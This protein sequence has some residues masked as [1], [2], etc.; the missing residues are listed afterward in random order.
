MNTKTLLLTTLLSSTLLFSN[1]AKEATVSKNDDVKRF[2]EAWIKTK[3]PNAT[4]TPLGVYILGSTEGTGET[5]EANDFI[6]V[7]YTVKSLNN[8]IISTN[9]AEVAKQIGKYVPTY[10]YGTTIWKMDLSSISVG[11]LDAVKGMKIGGSKTIL[12]PGWLNVH[13]EHK[14]ESEYLEKESGN[15]VIC[16]LTLQKKVKD[17]NKWEE[18]ILKEFSKKMPNAKKEK[19]GLYI[20]KLRENKN[21]K[22]ELK[23]DTTV[24]I[25]YTGRLL[26]G[27]VFDTTIED[28]AK[29]YNIYSENKKY[30]PVSIQLSKDYKKIKIN[31]KDLIEGFKYGISL[32]NDKEKVIFIFP[33]LLG[34][35]NKNRNKEAIPDHSP[36]RF[37]V[38]IIGKK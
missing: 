25:N 27:E 7:G 9:N 6:F 18:K 21:K 10:P 1:C 15:T 2:I 30:G 38:E 19:E 31:N 32:M 20:Q 4:K 3:H 24:N 36:L 33:S 17:I 13:K 11:M 35:E 16:E 14:T 12:I 28:T 29:V 37:D 34:Y 26:T 22:S 8:S 5:I 23:K